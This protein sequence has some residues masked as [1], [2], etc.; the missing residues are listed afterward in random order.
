M[1]APEPRG[2][3][4][5]VITV[6]LNP[7][8]DRTIEV[9]ALV[10]GAVHRA[11]QVRVDAGGKG[12]NIARALGANGHPALAVLPC[13]GSDGDELA[14]L[15]SRAGVPHAAVPIG[16]E[17]RTNVSIVEP[18]GTVTK[19][20]TPGPTLTAGELDAVL[21][22]TLAAAREG[23]W[24]A[25]GGSLPPGVADDVYARLT[26][27]LHE[28]GSRVAVDSTGAA[29]LAA[30]PLHPDVIKPNHEELAEAAGVPV[31]TLGEAAA[32]ARVLREQGARAVLV[33][34]GAD[35]VLLVDDGGA[36]TAPRRCRRS[37]APSA[38]ATRRSP[39]SSPGA[40]P[41][42]RPSPRPSPGAPPRSGCR[43]AGCR[44]PP[45][46]AATPSASTP[47]PTQTG[48]SAPREPPRRRR[49]EPART[50]PPETP[51]PHRR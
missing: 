5:A 27:A 7:S 1:T 6:T 2:S 4:P 29:L 46:S 10:P 36:C 25:L 33:S 45:T 43:A 42:P 15:L 49:R 14:L 21:V 9:D 30:L 26:A 35:G 34:L 39:A 28:R 48:R 31:R 50:A 13:G 18:S 19:I 22:A 3:A 41:A 8:L 17:V 51:N 12:V 47:I 32:A 16:G 11:G 24:V 44:H 38:P 20:N 40:E 23:T 37:A